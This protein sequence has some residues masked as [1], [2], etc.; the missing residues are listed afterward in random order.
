MKSAMPEAAQITLAAAICVGFL[1]GCDDSGNAAKPAATTS[2][3]Q[4]P[5]AAGTSDQRF[6]DIV[7]AEVTEDA[8]GTYTFAITVSSPY[9]TA[10]RYADGWRII[11]PDGQVYGEHMLTHD[12][13]SEQSFTRPNPG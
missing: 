7:G 12:H 4:S 1:V 3:H 6:P 2:S 11:G 9:D 13:A 10:R 5:D 8:S